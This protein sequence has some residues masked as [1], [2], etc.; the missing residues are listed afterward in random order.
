MLQRVGNQLASPKV[1]SIKV[2]QL[3]AQICN[4]RFSSRDP[5]GNR[6][7]KDRTGTEIVSLLR[8]RTAAIQGKFW[9]VVARTP[10]CCW[11]DTSLSPPAIHKDEKQHPL[12]K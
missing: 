2:Q 9:F 1:V 8:H 11:L 4:L 3:P 5:S 12:H 7:Q 6:D 10:L